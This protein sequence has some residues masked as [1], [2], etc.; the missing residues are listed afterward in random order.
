L[1]P[2]SFNRTFPIFHHSYSTRRSCAR[3]RVLLGGQGQRPWLLCQC[4]RTG[5]ARSNASSTDSDTGIEQTA[6]SG[7]E[8]R[9]S[10]QASSN[11]TRSTPWG[12]SIAKRLCCPHCPDRATSTPHSVQ[13]SSLPE[14]P[15][16]QVDT[17]APPPPHIARSRG[18]RAWATVE[19][20][21]MPT[22]TSFL[23]IFLHRTSG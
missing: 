3:R 8:Q 4:M 17:I 6:Y 13:Y 10:R 5:L 2:A 12:R 1:H 11:S 7:R 18:G 21:T 23:R 19:A 9:P 22:I 14:S 15:H 20:N 16:R